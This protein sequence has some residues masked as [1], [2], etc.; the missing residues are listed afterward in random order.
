MPRH[1]GQVV[2][3]FDNGIVFTCKTAKEYLPWLQIILEGDIN[4]LKRP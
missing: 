4:P 3:R 2:K 1:F